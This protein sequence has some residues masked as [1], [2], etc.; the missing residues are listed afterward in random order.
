MLAMF[1]IGEGGKGNP[2]AGFPGLG[3]EATLLQTSLTQDTRQQRLKI[4]V[5]TYRMMDIQ[6]S[7]FKIRLIEPSFQLFHPDL[8]AAFPAQ[9]EI[10]W[11]LILEINGLQL[12]IG[13]ELGDDEEAGPIDPEEAGQREPGKIVKDL[14]KYLIPPPQLHTLSI[15]LGADLGRAGMPVSSHTTRDTKPSL[16]L[17][18]LLEQYRGMYEDT[19]SLE[20]DSEF[21][22]YLNIAILYA[23]PQAI[24]KLAEETRAK[25]IVFGNN[26]TKR[27]WEIVYPQQSSQNIEFREIGETDTQETDAQEIGG[28]A[29]DDHISIAVLTP[30]LPAPLAV[31]T[32]KSIHKWISNRKAEAQATI[33]VVHTCRKESREAAEKIKEELEKQGLKVYS[34]PI[35][36]AKEPDWSAFAEDL[37]KMGFS[38]IIVVS[39]F[40]KEAV[41][42]TIKKMGERPLYVAIPKLRLTSSFLRWLSETKT[43]P[44]KLL[45]DFQA[46]LNVEYT[47]V[48]VN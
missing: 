4:C 8:V 37:E 36:P 18:N 38:E 22:N 16:T 26:T 14:R 2:V 10:D 31:K 39:E 7:E 13:V 30:T 45:A 5:Y 19:A 35:N 29:P 32:A 48:R 34:E 40:P 11:F 27:K 3:H 9:L 33:T 1:K 42:A 24:P 47:I 23:A 20:E 12:K 17:K 41:V 21:N 28:P 25:L 44:D 6:N 15:T 46:K 43:N